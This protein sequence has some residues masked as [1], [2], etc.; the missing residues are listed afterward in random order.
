MKT[1]QADVL[2]HMVHAMPKWAQMVVNQKRKTGY[3]LPTAVGLPFHASIDSC[4]NGR[5]G[6]KPLNKKDNINSLSN[7]LSLL[8]LARSNMAR[9]S[10]GVSYSKLVGIPDYSTLLEYL[11]TLVSSK[12]ACK[13]AD[14]SIWAARFLRKL[15]KS[16]A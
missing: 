5:S 10:K 14:R 8:N 6:E 11:P 7:T 15:K 3:G 13:S 1:T 2:F 16:L 12:G 4:I 9:R